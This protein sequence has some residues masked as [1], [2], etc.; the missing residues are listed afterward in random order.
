LAASATDTVASTSSTICSLLPIWRRS[1]PEPKTNLNMVTAAGLTAVC[2]MW[3]ALAV[4]C[5]ENISWGVVE[6][7]STAPPRPGHSS[8][9]CNSNHFEHLNIAAYTKSRK[10]EARWLHG[11]FHEFY[12]YLNSDCSR[13]PRPLGNT[14][15]VCE[16]SAFLAIIDQQVAHGLPPLR[17]RRLNSRSTA[18]AI[19]SVR[20]SG[21]LPRRRGLSTASIRASVPLTNR[22][23][24]ASSQ[25][26]FR[27]TRG[28]IA[29]SAIIVIQF[30]YGV[31]TPNMS[32][33]INKPYDI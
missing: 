4:L 27:P 15:L 32:Y 17:V 12:F 16:R 14:A 11:F 9:I 1:D 25:R 31:L 23:P 10:G 30:S 8:I 21:G 24:C 5:K 13:P 6:G 28:R 19:K 18:S 7:K 3:L 2:R 26:C 29:D 20:Y 33:G 22:A